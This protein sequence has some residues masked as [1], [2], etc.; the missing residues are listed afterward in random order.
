[1]KY[2]S[3]YM[4]AKQTELFNSTGTFFAFSKA[5]FNEGKKDGIK[6]TALDGGM[7]CPT[8][9]VKDLVKGLDIIYNDA[10][11][12]DVKEN[13]IDKVIVRELYNHECFYTFRLDDVFEKLEDYPVTKERIEE[14]FEKEKKKVD[15]D[16]Y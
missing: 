8:E 7:L 4:Q 10:I 3:D 16:N 1:M 13:G 15:W 12:Q 2:L 9:K 14:E 5:Q 11:K 6:Y